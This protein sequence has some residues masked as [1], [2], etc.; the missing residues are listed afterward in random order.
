MVKKIEKRFKKLREKAETYT[1]V[2]TGDAL[3]AVGV[4]DRRVE[5]KFKDAAG[6][7]TNGDTEP[8]TLKESLGQ[9]H[10]QGGNDYGGTSSG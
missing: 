1:M 9:G 5:I 7:L 2:H 3:T 8:K 4:A 10:G 6:K